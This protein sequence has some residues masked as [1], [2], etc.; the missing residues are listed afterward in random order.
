MSISNNDTILS[1]DDDSQYI[2]KKICNNCPKDI[3]CDNSDCLKT[4]CRECYA[5]CEFGLLNC[6]REID[7][8][9]PYC[10]GSY[11]TFTDNAE[12]IIA[13]FKTAQYFLK[14]LELFYLNSLSFF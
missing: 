2:N 4:Y 6:N 12:H 9:C 8:Q 5:Y 7:L 11:C 14:K 1:E 13:G 10:V 3:K